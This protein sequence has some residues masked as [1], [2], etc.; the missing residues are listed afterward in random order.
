MNYLK[1]FIA[2]TGIMVG[3]LSLLTL[4][5]C[6]FV[7]W[8]RTRPEPVKTVRRQ[9]VALAPSRPRAR[10][11]APPAVDPMRQD[12]I[13]ALVNLGASKKDAERRATVAF[14][15]GVAGFDEYFRRA[16]AA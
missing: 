14:S 1:E 2:L 15:K 3:L 12:I 4:L 5:F 10:R 8:Y 16:V 6:W 9:A 13:S 11:A 7:V